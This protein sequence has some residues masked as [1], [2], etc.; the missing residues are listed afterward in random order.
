MQEAAYQ[1]SLINKIQRLFPE[2]YIL[3]N[4]PS[5]TQGLPDLL[6]LFGSEYAMLE[7][8]VSE[9]APVQPNQEYYIDK[10]NEMAFAAFIWPEIEEDVLREL[11]KKWS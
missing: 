2:C 4:D 6:I 1:H 11:K 10:F 5:E 8:K 7:T 9:N 3:K